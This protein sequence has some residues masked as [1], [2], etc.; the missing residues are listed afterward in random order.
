[1][2]GQNATAIGSRTA[3]DPIAVADWLDGARRYRRP[4]HR[5]HDGGVSIGQMG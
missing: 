5:T 3:R 4:A 1:V 2:R